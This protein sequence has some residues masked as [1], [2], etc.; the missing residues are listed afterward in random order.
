L[1]YDLTFCVKKQINT[2]NI[3]IIIIIKITQN[4]SKLVTVQPFIYY[5]HKPAKQQAVS[6]CFAAFC[7]FTRKQSEDGTNKFVPSER[8]REGFAIISEMK[9]YSTIKR[10]LT[11][12]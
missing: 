11:I 4:A 7:L 8:A 2:N 10:Y 12:Q 3:N 9:G 6:C 1:E 5:I